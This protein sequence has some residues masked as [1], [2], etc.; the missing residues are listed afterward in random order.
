MLSDHELA[1]CLQNKP[2]RNA[3]PDLIRNAIGIA[4]KSS[5]NVTA[6]AMA[7]KSARSI[8]DQSISIITHTLPI[9]TFTTTIQSSQSAVSEIGET[10]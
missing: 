6:L 7:W 10:I 4:G 3:V 9:E 8:E 5:D 2:I 1:Q